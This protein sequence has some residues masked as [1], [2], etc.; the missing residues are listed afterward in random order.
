MNKKRQ[1]TFFTKKVVFS[2]Y[3][4][5]LL[6][7]KSC[8]SPFFHLKWNVIIFGGTSEGGRIDK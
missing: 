7:E 1:L 2:T 5:A 4:P 3:S 8:L 6:T